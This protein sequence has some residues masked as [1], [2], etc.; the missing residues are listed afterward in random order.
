LYHLPYVALLISNPLTKLQSQPKTTPAS[1][2]GQATHPSGR[3]FERPSSDVLRTMKEH[4]L[5]ECDG[6]AAFFKPFYHRTPRRCPHWNLLDFMRGLRLR[7]RTQREFSVLRCLEWC[8]QVRARPVGKLGPNLGGMRRNVLPGGC[9]L[10]EADFAC[11]DGP[12]HD[13]PI[14]E[15][16][17]KSGRS[18]S[19]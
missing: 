6:Q 18:S 19:N 15:A 16:I 5:C 3:S 14:F 9:T 4:I 8:A 7:P 2:R 17:E 11:F 12:L 10:K 13:T 1:G